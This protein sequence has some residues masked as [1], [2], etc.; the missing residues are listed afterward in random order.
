MSRRVERVADAI[1]AAIAEILL[2]E[3][4]DPRVGM[5]TITGVRL[6][7]DLRH[8]RVFFSVFGDEARRE[9][10]LEGLRRAAGFIRR[11]LAR[12]VET[13]VSPQLVFEYDAGI[14]DSERMS[15][16]LKEDD[17]NEPQ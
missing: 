13:R 5:V 11:E 14:E 7:P 16:L 10:A 17:R 3:L 2:R 6:S 1:R 8:A 4:K 9:S 12:R 15:R